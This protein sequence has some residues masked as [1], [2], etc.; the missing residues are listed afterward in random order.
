MSLLRRQFLQLAAGTAV[1]P[2]LSTIA[3]SQAYPVRPVRVLVPYAPAGPSDI[4]ARIV[5]QKLSERLGKQFYVENVGGAGGNIGMGQGAR[6]TPDGYTVLVVPPNIV[7]N[8]A[9]YDS[10]PY[11]PYR[12]FDPVTVAVSSPTVLTVHPSLP[13]QTVKE[14]VDLIKS[15]PGRFSFASPGTGT[16]PHLIGE[17]FR[18]SLDLDLVH[19][20]FN[21][22]GLAIGATLAGHTPVAFTSLPPAVPQIRDGKLHA[23]AVTSKIR[24][25]ALPDVPSMAEAGYPEVIGEG[26]FAFIVPARTPKDIIA[27]LQREI[28]AIVSLPDITEKMAELGF[29]AVGDTPDEA[30]ALFRSESA[31]WAKVIRAANIKAK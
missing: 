22:A 3:A 29:E 27:L 16:P 10:V 15:S 1:M 11:D 17:Q 9:M 28:V 7:V 6:A 19:V 2:A 25:Q 18:L 14:M 31:K 30:A 23:L 5:S 21:S 24:S 26:W 13:V 8:P 12:D 20:P 4:L